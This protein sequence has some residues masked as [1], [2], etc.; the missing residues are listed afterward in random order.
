M[1]GAGFVLTGGD[2]SR[3]GL[4]K[5][6]L[7]FRGATLVQWIARQALDAAGEVH[8][9]GAP[10]RYAQLGIPCLP[11]RYPGCG[12]L[13]GI[14]AALRERAAD[15]SLILACDLPGAAAGILSCLFQ[16]ALNSPADA[17]IATGPSGR[18][19]PLFA[20]Y[21]ARVLPAV[22]SALHEGRLSVRELLRRLRVDRFPVDSE[23][24]LANVNTPRDWAQWTR[25]ADVD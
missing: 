11:E 10:E 18:L 21:H 12:P 2:S 7:P 6:L 14:E 5:A 15:W 4:D 19:Q 13:S 17:V 24:L 22:Q 9:V 8:L 23:N 1:T 20:A 25:T 3:M 16:T